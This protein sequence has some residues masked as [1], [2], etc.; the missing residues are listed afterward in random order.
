MKKQDFASLIVY[1]LML[2]IAL[3][4]GFLVIQPLFRDNSIFPGAGGLAYLYTFLII[5]GALLFNIIMLEVFHI[6]GG[7]LG[8]YNIVAVNI[9]GFC[10]FKDEKKWKFG[11]RSFDGLTGETTLAP[12]SEKSNPKPFVWLPLLGYLL[13]LVVGLVLYTLGSQKGVGHNLNVLAVVAI[14]FV[15]VSSMIALYNF[16][17]IQLDSMTDGYRL[18]LISK[19]I[20]VEAYNELM[21]V[22]N[23]QRE[24]KKVEEIKIFDEITEFTASINLLSAYEFLGDKD[25]KKAEELIDKIIEDPKKISSS[26]YHRLLAQKLHIK[27]MTLPLE[28]ARKYYDEN[29]DDDARRFIS[30]DV[31][32]ESIRAYVLIAGLLDE[33]RGEVMYAAS[34]KDKALK[35]SLA[36]RAKIEK[37]LFDDAIKMVKE[38]HPDWDL[39][40]K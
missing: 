24:G 35:R 2:G 15:A 25:F 34:K 16:V 5:V 19:P 40:I 18:T 28:E 38:A 29:V 9:L 8:K 33:S 10:W 11:F 13:E 14:V 31:S 20:N 12:K 21:R 27:I 3:L 26:T 23:L 30:N 6:L 22:E 1:V 7:K 37:E 36:S 32:M 4:I 17:P 39:D